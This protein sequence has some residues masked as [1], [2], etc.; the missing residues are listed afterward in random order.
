MELDAGL[1]NRIQAVLSGF[2]LAMVTRRVFLIDWAVNTKAATL[3]SSELSSMPHWNALFMQPYPFL[4][5]HTAFGGNVRRA[6]LS[7]SRTEFDLN[8]HANRYIDD[9]G[10]A[11]QSLLCENLI[12][13]FESID[14]VQV[15]GYDW[16]APTLAA[17]PHHFMSI[18]ASFGHINMFPSLFSHLFRP[19]LDVLKVAGRYRPKF[20]RF[21]VIGVQIRSIL[22]FP[23]ENERW[24]WRTMLHL[25][26]QAEA[27]QDKPVMFYVCSDTLPPWNRLQR[28]FGKERLMSASIQDGFIGRSNQKDVMY[29][30]VDMLL[31]G[32]CDD[33]IL[34]PESTFGGVAAARVGAQPWRIT[35]NPLNATD[36]SWDS[37]RIVARAAGQSPCSY[38]WQFVPRASC[39]SK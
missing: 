3:P 22:R 14:T 38:G 19:T 20:E 25:Q 39:F 35:K 8:G 33:I 9:G 24:I 12:Q 29:G 5:H 7:P 2:L 11:Y 17:N 4:T 18:F 30:V 15:N 28:V 27:V 37:V 10:G 31:L 1:G 23:K 32:E 6:L 16:F 21:Y 13:Q 26:A 36:A 34:S